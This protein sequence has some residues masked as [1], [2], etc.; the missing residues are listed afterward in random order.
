V[1]TGTWVI[2]RAIPQPDRSLVQSQFMQFR[3][4]AGFDYRERILIATF[5]Q[6]RLIEQGRFRK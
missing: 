4:V 2:Y 6:D 5:W 3:D 1:A